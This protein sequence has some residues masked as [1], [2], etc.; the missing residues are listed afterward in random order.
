MSTPI[1]NMFTPLL[2]MEQLNDLRG[3][4]RD[5]EEQ[6]ERIVAEVEQLRLPPDQRKRRSSVVWQDG[7]ST[8]SLQLP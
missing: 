6:E 8:F 3:R 7:D 2:G 5:L 1:F 4:Y